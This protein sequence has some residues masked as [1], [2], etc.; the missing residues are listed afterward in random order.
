M[1]SD[2]TGKA[3]AAHAVTE[4]IGNAGLGSQALTI[5]MLQDVVIWTPSQIFE[6]RK[7][8]RN[9]A[10]EFAPSLLCEIAAQPFWTVG[11]ATAIYLPHALQ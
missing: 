2:G 5:L 8:G 1:H 7:R 10:R 6:N 3:R 11:R 9:L 4:G